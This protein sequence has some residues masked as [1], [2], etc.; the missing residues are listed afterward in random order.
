MGLIRREFPLTHDLQPIRR[1]A[2]FLGGQSGKSVHVAL[3]TLYRSAYSGELE[4]N[5][6]QCKT[7]R[8]G[9][10]RAF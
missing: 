9:P 2:T 5:A 7:N 3:C 6:V 4:L 8:T 10:F 1:R